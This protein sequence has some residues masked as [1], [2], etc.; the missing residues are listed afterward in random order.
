MQL[1]EAYEVGIPVATS[2]IS[3]M[4]EVAGKA[5][6]YFD[7]TKTSEIKTAI[8]QVLLDRGLHD[9]LADA[10]REQLKNFSWDKCARETLAVLKS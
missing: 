3:S 9:R 7:P 6:V 5:A 4:P 1:L 2:N 8:K 10:G